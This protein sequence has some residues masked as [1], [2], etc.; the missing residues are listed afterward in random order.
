[1]AGCVVDEQ[2]RLVEGKAQAVGAI[3]IVHQQRRRLR[4]GAG[5]VDAWKESSC[6]RST[7]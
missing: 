7:P 5:A 4:I 3:E 1:L 2:A 6:A